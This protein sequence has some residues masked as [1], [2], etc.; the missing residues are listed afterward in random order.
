[1]NAVVEEAWDTLP[2]E[3]QPGTGCSGQAGDDFF[4]RL[5]LPKWAERQGFDEVHIEPRRDGPREWC[6]TFGLGQT[7][8][9]FLG[10]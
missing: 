4:T 5:R 6:R 9:C 10:K 3:Q 7:L 2:E 1:M 8:Q